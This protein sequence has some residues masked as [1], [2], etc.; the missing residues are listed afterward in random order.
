MSRAS[1][2]ALGRAAAERSMIDTCTVQRTTGESEGPGGVITPT[3]STVYTGACRV[4]VRAETGTQSDVGEAS[5]ILTRHEIHLP[6]SAVGIREGDVV[7]ITASTNDP[8]LVGRTYAV[9]DVL[10]KSEA[11]ARRVT[12]VEVNS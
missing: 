8:D 3:T 1:V 11:T 5:L 4:Q 9:R 6:I 7:T 10:T 2:L 12:A